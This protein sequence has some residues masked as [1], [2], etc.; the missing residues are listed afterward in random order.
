MAITK[1]TKPDM[2]VTFGGMTQYA[3]SLIGSSAVQTAA[4]EGVYE[5]LAIAYELAGGAFDA[6]RFQGDVA[7]R[8]QVNRA[9]RAA[10]RKAEELWAQ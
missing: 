5:G 4:I 9:I 7:E 10:Q 8:E 2:Y 1:R 3:A 6:S